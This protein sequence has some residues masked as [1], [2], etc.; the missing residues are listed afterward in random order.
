MLSFLKKLLGLGQKRP[1][2]CCGGG[3]CGH[4][5]KRPALPIDASEASVVAGLDPKIVI[6]K[7]HAITA[8][9]D[10]KVTK[11]QITQTEIAPGEMRQILCGAKNIAVGQMVPVATVGASLS[12]DFVISE[13]KIRGELS[14]G[15]ICAKDELG[16]T[17][18]TDGIWELP[19]DFEKFLGQSL[20]Q[21]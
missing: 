11:V 7:I 16:F 5:K 10:P 20:N 12:A 6:G 9:P 18:E 15:M 21:F 4:E 2:G 14:Q 13:R 17:K 19:T 3:C 1:A 8:H